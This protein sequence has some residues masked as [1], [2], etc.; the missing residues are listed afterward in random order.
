MTPAT[1]N[2]HIP[3]GAGGAGKPRTVRYLFFTV[4][5][6]FITVFV[7]LYIPGVYFH[8]TFDQTCYIR[9]FHRIF[10]M[11]ETGVTVLI[12]ECFFT[13]MNS[14]VYHQSWFFDET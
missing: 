8:N 6:V 12:L 1:T 9:I 5:Y 7:S 3:L 11:S 13:L 2:V 14:L 10:P 4:I